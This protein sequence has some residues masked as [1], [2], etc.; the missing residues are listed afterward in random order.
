MPPPALRRSSA[1]RRSFVP[2]A[3]SGR[4]S[5]ASFG[6]FASEAGAASASASIA[7]AETTVLNCDSTSTPGGTVVAVAVTPRAA[8]SAATKAPQEENRSAGSFER[9]REST[10]STAGE[11]PGR[12]DESGGGGD[13]TCW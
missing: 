13:V 2:R 10:A 11:V 12:T 8:P 6:F 7:G 5:C 1:A 9:P 3:A 4:V